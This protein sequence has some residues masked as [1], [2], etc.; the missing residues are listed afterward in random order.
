MVTRRNIE[1]GS[2]A[3]LLSYRERDVDQE[4]LEWFDT[5]ED[6]YS[7]AVY[8]LELGTPRSEKT[9]K[10]SW[11]DWHNEDPP[12]W[13]WA[14]YYAQSVY[15]VG[16]TSNMWHRIRDHVGH[17]EKGAKIVYAFPPW[18]VE[19]IWPCN[20]EYEAFELEERAAEMIEEEKPGDVFVYQ[21]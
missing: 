16:A 18:K 21:S 19:K 9:L 5:L 13:A 11:W 8:C 4:L 10:N 7:P 12:S 3:N 2:W 17:P 14:A 6:A 15:Y 1:P 20:S